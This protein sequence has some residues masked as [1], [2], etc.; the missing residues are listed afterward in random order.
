MT[1]RKNYWHRSPVGR[2][3]VLRGAAVSGAGLVGA[4]L[5][6]CGGGDDEASPAATAAATGAATAVATEAAAT[7][8]K[9]GG[10]YRVSST[11]DPPTLDPYGSGSAWTKAVAAYAYSRLFK[12]DV[13]PDT[14]P[15]DQPLIPDAAS[16]Y[17]APDGQVWVV[18]L[19]PGVKFHNIEP[20]NGR[21]LVAEDVIYS[22][23]R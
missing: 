23:R 7:G 8:P 11:G 21:E 19:R 1:E 2:R 15:Y 22:W 20:V 3:A 18:K 17:E 16:G 5:I 13:A 9:P 14:N 10:T 12:V 4:A 6:G